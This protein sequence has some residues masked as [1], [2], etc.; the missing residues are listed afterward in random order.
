L[1]IC[2]LPS[3]LQLLLL[4]GVVVVVVLLLHLAVHAICRRG[5]SHFC[6]CCG[7]LPAPA[8]LQCG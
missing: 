2:L 7:Q 1:S 8:V 4:L 6:T 3:L 5:C